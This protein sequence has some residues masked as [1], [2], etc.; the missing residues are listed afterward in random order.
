M[1]KAS[2]CQLSSGLGKRHM[3][4]CKIRIGVSYL[5]WVHGS[6]TFP[7]FWHFAAWQELAGWLWYILSRFMN[8]VTLRLSF[9]WWDS[10]CQSYL[11][12]FAFASRPRKNCG[13]I[14]FL[15]GA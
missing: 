6:I 7:M 2:F 9:Q 15:G 12:A 4:Y 5:E 3:Q 13:D 8:H 11:P 14:S 1:H 10:C